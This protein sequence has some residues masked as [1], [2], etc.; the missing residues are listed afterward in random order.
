M[1]N[2]LV[3]HYSGM[4]PTFVYTETL[5]E[6]RA[7]ALTLLASRP[8]KASDILSIVEIASDRIMFYGKGEK[9]AAKLIAVPQHGRSVRQFMLRLLPDWMSL[10]LN[11]LSI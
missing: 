9:M 11:K 1:Q 10:K 2:Y 7:R 3:V 8:N 5:D 4:E 6:A